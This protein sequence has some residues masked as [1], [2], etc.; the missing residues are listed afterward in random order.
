MVGNDHLNQ[1]ALQHLPK[2]IAI[3]EL[4]NR[5]RTLELGRAVGNAFGGKAKIMR[6]GLDGDR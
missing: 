1:P 5:R 6:T 3:P 2:L 4:A